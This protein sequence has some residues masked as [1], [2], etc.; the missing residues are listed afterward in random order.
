MECYV[1]EAMPRG[2][3]QVSEGR[4]AVDG[5]KVKLALRFSE[6]SDTDIAK[7]FDRHPGLCNFVRKLD[8][9]ID[10]WNG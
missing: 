1:A 2:F 10:K 4:V 9:A 5:N 7:C 3:L 8:S 6:L